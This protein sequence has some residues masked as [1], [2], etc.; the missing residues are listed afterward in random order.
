MSPAQGI[1]QGPHPTF[2]EGR[3]TTGPYFEDGLDRL[4]VLGIRGPEHLKEILARRVGLAGTSRT[5]SCKS[6]RALNGQCLRILVRKAMP[7]IC[8]GFRI[9][10]KGAAATRDPA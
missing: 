4:P 9:L 3:G 5:W 10:A 8:C 2:V 7:A 6:E 1:S